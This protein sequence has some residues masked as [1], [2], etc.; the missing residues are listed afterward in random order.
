MADVNVNFPPSASPARFVSA[1]DVDAAITQIKADVEG[2]VSELAG[3][4]AGNAQDIGDKAKLGPN[5]QNLVD[6]IAARGVSVINFGAKGDYN[7]VTGIGTNNTQAIKDAIA[8][9]KA[10][11]GGKIHLDG[12]NFLITSSLVVPGNVHLIGL[13]MNNTTITTATNDFDAIVIEGDARGVTLL[14]FNLQ[15]K[16]GIGTSN[17]GIKAD[18]VSGGAEHLYRNMQINGF[19]Y[20]LRVKDIWWNN[21]VENVRWNRCQY[22]LYGDGVGGLTI[23]NLFIRC[24]SNE[25]LKT[26]YHLLAFKNT[27]FLACNFGGHPTLETKY[28]YLSTANNSLKF[29]G[30]NF[31][32]IILAANDA[33]LEVWSTTTATFEDCT[34]VNN[35]GTTNGF[36]IK[37][38]DTSVVT[39]INCN[40][41]QPGTNIKQIEMVNSA[42]LINLSPAFNDVTHTAG[43]N[44]Q[45]RVFN[46][47]APR[48]IQTIPLTLNGTAQEIMALRYQNGG[49]LIAA[50]LIYS[51]A[52]SADAGVQITLKNGA[53]TVTYFDVVSEVSKA[54]WSVVDIPLLAT[55]ITTSPII[56]STPGG[57]VGTGKVILEL[58][59]TLDK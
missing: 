6:I 21:T 18:P 8:F 26:G 46:V 12:K 23:N 44:A 14:D 41:I 55:I 43:S 27:T 9:M 16:L 2:Q 49:R 20:G 17:A 39:L 10:I 51:E 33:G 56:F 42:Q 15:S 52:T 30:C 54:K 19:Y 47:K 32:K 3:Q 7:P 50:R 5:P 53:N 13:G 29:I 24:Y 36:E 11:G 35:K 4:V 28:L 34:F 22:S 31:E 45:T 59:Y 25:P 38:R 58:E 57:K 37:L 1:S 40:Q 48:T